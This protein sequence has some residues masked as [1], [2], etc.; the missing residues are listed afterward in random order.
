MDETSIYCFSTVENAG[1]T[2]ARAIC[3]RK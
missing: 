3:A 1:A 2:R